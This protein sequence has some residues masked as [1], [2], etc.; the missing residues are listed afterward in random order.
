MYIYV[1][2]GMHILEK[3]YRMINFMH[4]IVFV[5]RRFYWDISI[6][7]LPPNMK[8]LASPLL[9]AEGPL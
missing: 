5:G 2:F 9:E 4:S 6:L 7:P 3:D 8:Q 1:S